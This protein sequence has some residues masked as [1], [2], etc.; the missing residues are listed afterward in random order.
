MYKKLTPAVHRARAY[1]GNCVLI[2]RHLFHPLSRLTVKFDLD[3]SKR[4]GA[5]RAIG[6]QELDK[7]FERFGETELT[8]IYDLTRPSVCG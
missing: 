8:E 3:G 5:A 6:T 7:L 4:M 1:D 2:I